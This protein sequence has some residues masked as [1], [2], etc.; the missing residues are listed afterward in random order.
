M[1]KAQKSGLALVIGAVVGAIAAFLFGTDKA[2]D[3]KKEVKAAVKKTKETIEKVDKKK[4]LKKVDDTAK[5]VGKHIEE[6]VKLFEH[7]F[8]DVKKTFA[9]VDKAKY[10]KAVTQVVDELKKTGK[11][12]GKQL[13]EIKDF[14]MADYTKIAKKTVKKGK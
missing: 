8:G 14:L 5:K 12:T 2:G 1:K 7:K 3:T 10:Q 6:A 13:V 9:N 11:T 4:V